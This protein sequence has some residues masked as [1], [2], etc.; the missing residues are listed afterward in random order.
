MIGLPAATQESELQTANDMI[1]WGIDAARI[2]P[3]VVFADTALA[4]M[5]QKGDYKELTTEDAI[6]RSSAVYTRFLENGIDVIRI[7]LCENEGLHSENTIGGA[8]HP[9][10][11]ELIKSRHYLTVIQNEIERIMPPHSATIVIEAPQKLFSQ[12]LGQKKK[13]LRTLEE[14]Y[15]N[16]RFLFQPSP[17]LTGKD[18]KIF[19]KEN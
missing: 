8:H 15:P 5:M 3:T 14:A 6:E 9:A 7:G 19:I 2:Y 12:V 18:V 16:C 13:N 10:L 4:V 1:A 17:T 11:G